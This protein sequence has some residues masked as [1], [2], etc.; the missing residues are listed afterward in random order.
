MSD[1]EGTQWILHSPDWTSY[2]RDQSS[3]P[4]Q[5][6]VV[7]LIRAYAVFLLVKVGFSP[8]TFPAFS[9]RA[10]QTGHG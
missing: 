6:I 5:E 1:Y 8:F 9:V 3:G 7:K 4:F 10:R 2:P